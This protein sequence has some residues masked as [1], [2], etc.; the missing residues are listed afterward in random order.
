MKSRL[1]TAIV[2]GVGLIAASSLILSTGTSV[3]ADAPVMN[4]AQSAATLQN[5]T[6]NVTGDWDAY[7]SF[8]P[9]SVDTVPYEPVGSVTT[10]PNQS[11]VQVTMPAQSD[12]CDGAYSNC[13][14]VA[15]E[16]ND[17]NGAALNLS[18]SSGYPV[19]G[20]PNTLYFAITG[21]LTANYSAVGY[22]V[23][24]DTVILALG[25]T[26]TGSY[27]WWVKFPNDVGLSYDNTSVLENPA[28]CDSLWPTVATPPETSPNV[29]NFDPGS[30]TLPSGCTIG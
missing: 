9:A 25:Q 20:K 19:I 23:F 17:I 1:K 29:T 21:T 7:M 3:G 24:S 13:Y 12:W 10:A 2:A 11:S 5:F 26:G 15:D 18:G 14:T 28:N 6:V 8:T 16:F 27:N 22:P 4:S 30:Q